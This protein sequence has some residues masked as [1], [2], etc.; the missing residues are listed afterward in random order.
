MRR[1]TLVLALVVSALAAAVP[2]HAA[3]KASVAALQVALGAKGFYRGQIDGIRGPRTAAALRRFQRRVG[4]RSDGVV[5]PRTRRALGH[6]GRPSLGS[7]PLRQ[8][9]VGWDVAVVQFALAHH[10]F[11]SHLDGFFG[12]RTDAAVRA[13]QQYAGLGVD[14]VAGPATLA[15]LRGPART[16]FALRGEP[17]GIRAVTIAERYLGVPY[18]WGGADPL[19]GF[20]CS[21]LVMYVYG[22]LGISLLHASSLQ[23]HAGR[24][25]NRADLLPGDLVFLEPRRRGPRHVG[26]YIGRGWLIEAP[27][28]GDVV[29]ITG[30]RERARALGYV[31]AARPY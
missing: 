31:G 3:G 6:H 25:I 15:A 26:I 16:P 17:T 24:R 10:G 1:A 23:L 11:P 8:G 14:G 5:G 9:Q 20:D 28:T 22:R 7:R 12:D 4:L 18:L 30:L 21:G 27:R 2:A 29:R 13:F 19:T